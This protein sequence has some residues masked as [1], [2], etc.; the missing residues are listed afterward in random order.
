MHMA[1]PRLVEG[2]PSALTPDEHGMRP[3]WKSYWCPLIVC[4][5]SPSLCFVCLCVCVFVCVG[6]R[7]FLRSVAVCVLCLCLC[8]RARVCVCEGVRV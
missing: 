2:D 8:V 5:V 1:V 7:A 3:I 4:A 6:V